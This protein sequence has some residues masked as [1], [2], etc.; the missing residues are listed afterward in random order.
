MKLIKLFVAIALCVGLSVTVFA[1]SGGTDSKGGHYDHSTGE[2]HYHHGYPEHQHFD[3]TGD[4]IPDCPYLIDK[5][6]IAKATTPETTEVY[7]SPNNEEEKSE[8]DTFW[9]IVV[10]AEIVFVVILVNK[11]IAKLRDKSH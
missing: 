11:I 7:K 8:D 3:M 10:I 5:S 9:I 1:H 2:Y 4:G 6:E